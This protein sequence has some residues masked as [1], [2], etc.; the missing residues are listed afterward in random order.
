MFGQAVDDA[1]AFYFLGHV[2]S[3][4]HDG[5]V[6]LCGCA[7]ADLCEAFAHGVDD[8]GYLLAR[9]LPPVC[10]ACCDGAFLP[11]V[12]AIRVEHTH[13]LFNDG[14]CCVRLQLLG[15]KARA[16]AH[17]GAKFHDQRQMVRP[18]HAHA[19]AFFSG[20]PGWSL[21]AGLDAHQVTGRERGRLVGGCLIC[22]PGA[23]VRTVLASSG[24]SWR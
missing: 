1:P 18:H 20:A 15:L 10:C 21:E 13:A 23:G 9:Q 24:Q 2:D 3:A 5:G 14:V 12:S 6:H 22:C 4:V 19:A 8:G 17:A 16:L 11:A 7:G